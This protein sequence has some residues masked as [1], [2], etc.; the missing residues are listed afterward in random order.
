MVGGSASTYQGSYLVDTW[1]WDGVSWTP[2]TSYT[3][4]LDVG[5]M[6]YDSHRQ[7]MV[8]FR[9]STWEWDNLT[10]A[11]LSPTVAPQARSRHAMAY[12]AV[13]QRTVLF[14]GWDGPK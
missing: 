9:G 4:P 10:W 2:R 6:V 5:T 3:F 7:R 13:R 11:Q 14:G 12:D 8:M 1:E